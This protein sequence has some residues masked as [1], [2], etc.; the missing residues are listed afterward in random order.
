MSITPGS[1]DKSARGKVKTWV[2]SPWLLSSETL[3]T[4]MRDAFGRVQRL[5]PFLESHLVSV[6]PTLWVETCSSDE[7]RK[8]LFEQME[9]KRL[10]NYR[11]ISLLTQTR[12]SSIDLLLPSSRCHYP[13]PIGGLL[14]AKQLGARF[15]NIWKKRL[16]KSESRQ[17]V[18]R[19]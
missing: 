16:Q 14:T 11:L 6:E 4:Q 17:P 18:S 9:H 12:H 7:Q 2:T 13:Y 5:F 1:P 8:A 15:M 19:V 3:V 10:E